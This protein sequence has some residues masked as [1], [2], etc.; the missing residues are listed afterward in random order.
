MNKMIAI[1]QPTYMPW[2]GYFSMIDQVEE[3]VFL[4]NV[5][6]VNR[7]WQV[8]NKIKFNDAEKM[9]TI[10][11]DKSKHRDDRQIYNTKYYGVEWKDSHLGSI[12][13][14]YSKSQYFMEVMPFLN[15]LYLGDYNSIG[16]MNERFIIEI[17]NKIGINT[18]FY[19][20]KKMNVEGHKDKLL[21]DICK[22]LNADAYLSAM[23]S[24][25][26]IESENPAGEFGR[27]GI[28]LYYL[29]YDHPEYK[30]IGNGFIPYIG[31]YDLIFNVGLNDAL[32]IIREG[33]RENITSDEFRRMHLSKI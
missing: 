26:Y 1:M 9:L 32:E 28:E 25:S 24:A 27:C 4:D 18:K 16:D 2:L 12:R 5:Q 20:S 14:A 10:P 8:R 33:Q 11:V 31:I 22:K 19:F 6:L 30:Q 15:D 23:G 29:N 13:L 3:F 7:S 21:V 17:C